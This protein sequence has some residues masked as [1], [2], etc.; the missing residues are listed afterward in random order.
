MG[1]FQEG[2]LLI[3]YYSYDG[4][5]KMVD[6]DVQLVLPNGQIQKVTS[7]N[8]F[9]E[10]ISRYWSARQV[11]IPNLQK[12]CVLEYRFELR[13]EAIHMLHDWYFQDELSVRWS[14][15][16]IYILPFFASPSLRCSGWEKPYCRLL[17][18]L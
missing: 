16:N 10:K 7:D 3:P 13:S 9:T 18:P 6:L 1:A 17:T 4:L 12:G 14:E 8:V 11:F 5:E 15:L 2:N